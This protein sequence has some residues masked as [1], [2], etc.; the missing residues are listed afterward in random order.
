VPELK[1]LVIKRLKEGGHCTLMCGDG[2]NDVGALRQASV[3]VALLS[4]FG[5]M[6][7]DKTLNKV[8]FSRKFIY[9]FL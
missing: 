2:A 3:G 1:E 8:F 7:V 5:S 9:I 6:N 4:G